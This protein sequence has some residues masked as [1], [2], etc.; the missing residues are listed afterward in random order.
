MKNFALQRHWCIK[1]MLNLVYSTPAI[2]DIRTLLLHRKTIVIISNPKEC[3][4]IYDKEESKN[5]KGIITCQN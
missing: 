4:L 2:N 1:S 3:Y 5:M